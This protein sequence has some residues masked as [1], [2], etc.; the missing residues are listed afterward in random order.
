MV[1]ADLSVCSFVGEAFAQCPGATP[2]KARA[3]A[4][5]SFIILKTVGGITKQNGNAG[6]YPEMRHS[7]Y[8]K[9]LLNKLEALFN[10]REL[11]FNDL[12]SII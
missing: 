11:L 2:T 4:R 10:I 1:C 12:G 7:T 8:W 5:V 9:Y 6:I 3:K